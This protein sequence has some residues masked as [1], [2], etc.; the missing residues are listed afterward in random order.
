MAAI[1]RDVMTEHGAS[2]PGFAIHDSEVGA[3]SQAY[4]GGRSRYFVIESE[5]RVVGGGGFAPLAGADANTCELR[6]M[7]F[8]P[9]VRGLGLGRDLLAHCLEEMKLAGFEICYL[10]T[11]K[12]MARARKLYEAFGFTPRCSAL[13]G[14]GHFACDTY[15]EKKLT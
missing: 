12:S 14:T 6:K 11:L 9:S 10:E 5:G 1:I 7:Y 8:R 2:G 15:Y 3:M 4:P 13:G